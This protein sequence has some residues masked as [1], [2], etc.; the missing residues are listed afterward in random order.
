MPRNAVR[1]RLATVLFLDIVGSTALASELGD[2]RWRELLTRFRRIV[3]EELKRH[4]GR[5]QDTAGDGF[6]ATFDEPARA[7]SCAA[8][9]VVAVQQLGVDVRA[10]VHTGECEEIDG[11][12]GGIAV[13][14]GSRIMALAGPAE[15]LTT[16]TVMDL[17]SGS[18]ASFED[19]GVHELKGVE[20]SRQ[21]FSLRAVET[22]LPEPLSPAEAAAR[23][24][25]IGASKR[26]RP[27]RLAL[28]VA[29]LVVAAGVAVPLLAFGGGKG[30]PIG[31][32]RLDGHTGHIS[33]LERDT[34]SRGN[35]N[36][37]A[38]AGGTLWQYV[39]QKH[40]LLARDARSGRINYSFPIKIE[41]ACQVD[42]GFGSIWLLADR[43]V[44]AA[45]V[46]TLSRVNDASGRVVKRIKL[47]GTTAGGTVATGNGAVWVLEDGGEL[48][49]I[50]PLTNR[51]IRTYETH[52]VE[53]NTLVPLAG[54]DWICECVVNKILRFDPRNGH[55][56][57]YS[58]AAQAFLVG[59]NSSTLW[60]LDPQN[61][62]LTAVDP[63]TG[64]A[65]PPLGLE[66][67]PI[68]AVVAFGSM[69]AAAGDIVDRVDL[70]THVRSTIAMPKGV[71][72]G[73]I[74]SD[75]ASGAIWVENSGSAPPRH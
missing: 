4:G 10:G 50:D 2:A 60:L 5:E 74:A 28:A 45:D 47:P 38:S 12:L 37:L 19:R 27:I 72:A 53:T 62:T 39:G 66:G 51:I 25:L 43:V 48:F 54:Y 34:L 73:G 33:Q 6:F 44:D 65:Q 75:P 71:W 13:H 52:A 68:Q 3:R 1:R 15:V 14:I 64:Q 29:A 21:V 23:L 67:N 70:K 35:W 18:G 40:R 7:L 32:I 56:K 69:W 57:T 20:G 8:S 9:I 58:I 59:I 17:V 31:L 16:G 36:N 61:S 63:S 22:R 41:C 30:T 24:A 26:R 49:R 46:A 55:S 11:K 42:V